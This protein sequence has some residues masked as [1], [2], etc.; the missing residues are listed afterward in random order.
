MK[1]AASERYGAIYCMSYVQVAR[2]PLQN[3]TLILFSSISNLESPEPTSMK[4]S[5]LQS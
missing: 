3:R 2:P 4:L 5:L 1:L